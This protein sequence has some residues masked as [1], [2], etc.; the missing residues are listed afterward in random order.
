MNLTSS[1][2]GAPA[3]RLEQALANARGQGRAD[4]GPAGALQA[5]LL[6]QRL[7]DGLLR[8]RPAAA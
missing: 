2:P 6:A 5:A 1:S 3:S 7:T 4:P 8:S